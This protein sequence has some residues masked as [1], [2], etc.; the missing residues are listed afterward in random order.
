[1]KL[2]IRD[3]DVISQEKDLIDLYRF[4][5]FPVFMGCTSQNKK[6]DLLADM[7]WSISKNS[8]ALQLNPL[9]PLEIIYQDDHGSGCVGQLW[10]Q[11]HKFF[12]EFIYN[13][14]FKS[15]LEIGGLH[16]ILSKLYEDLDNNIDWTIIEPN[17]I[18]VDGVKAKFIKGYFDENFKLNKSIDAIV[19][20]HVFE[21]IYDPHSFLN[22]IS[23]FLTEGKHLLFSLP[24]L[25][26]MLKRKYNNALNFEHT[27]F[28][29]EPYIEYLLS[30]YHFRI[31]KREYFKEDHSIFYACIKDLKVKPV[32]LQKNLYELNRNTFLEYINYYKDLIKELNSK[33]EALDKGQTLYLFGAHIFSQYL[34][35]F[36][37][38]TNRL[39]CIIDNDTMKQGKRLYGSDFKVFSPKVL[40][41]K[42]PVVILKAGVYNDEIKKDI[43]TN[44]NSKTIFL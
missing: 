3:K 42:K 15:V 16:G 19:H 17:P 44:I 4:K 14:S 31:I 22:H 34:I 36:G 1:M 25:E 43:L 10:N 23:N 2:I 40:K 35:G 27:I 11:H 18:P 32:K 7:N 30:K 6:D 41:E 28:L 13:F 38:N 29:T 12:A 26:E 39:E 33:I 21:H 8:G 24:N 20:S 9:L 37:L 5:N